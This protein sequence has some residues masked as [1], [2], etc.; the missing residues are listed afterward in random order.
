M[1]LSQA[2]YCSLILKQLGMEMA[3]TASTLMVE[4]IKEFLP[5]PGS[6]AAEHKERKQLPYRSLTES[7]LYLST[8]I[9]P[10]ITFSVRMFGRFVER[11]TTA[12]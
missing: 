2:T 8:H 11:H 6:S 9:C 12:H 10:D 7:L 3:K 5:E 4:N 1:F